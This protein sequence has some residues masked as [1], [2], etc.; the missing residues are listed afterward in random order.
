VLR[1]AID[2]ELARPPSHNRPS[3]QRRRS[4]LGRNSGESWGDRT[5]FGRLTERDVSHRHARLL[6]DGGNYFIEDL[7][8]DNGTRVDAARIHGKVQIDDRDLVEI[9]GYQLFV[10]AMADGDRLPAPRAPAPVNVA[11]LATT[12]LP[13]SARSAAARGIKVRYAAKTEAGSAR[14]INADYFV[15]DTDA[16]LFVVADGPDAA[17][18]KRAGDVI[19]AF[20]KRTRD[21]DATWPDCP[22]LDRDGR[23]RV[24]HTPRKPLWSDQLDRCVVGYA[25][26]GQL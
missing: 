2:P 26:V 9:G 14:R 6:R 7:D 20:Y 21:D 22:P 3:R 17:A 1:L 19:A 23:I 24:Q 13:P 5:A 18:S 11:R 25:A 4:R 8:S 16:E 10:T 12:S 15:V